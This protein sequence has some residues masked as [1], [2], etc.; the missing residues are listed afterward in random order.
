MEFRVWSSLTWSLL[1]LVQ[2]V[3]GYEIEQAELRAPPARPELHLVTFLNKPDR[4]FVYLQVSAEAHD[5]QPQYLGMG[6]A[7]VWPH[8]L[9]KVKL[10][11]HYVDLK[12]ADNDIVIFADAFDVLVFGD[13]TE[14]ISKFE[15][16]EASK[17]RSIFFNAEI[18]CYPPTAVCEEPY[19]KAPHR[20]RY[21]NS[22][23]FVARGWALRKLLPEGEPEPQKKGDQEWY[24]KQFHARPDLVALDYECQLVCPI[25]GFL[26]EHGAEMW[27]DNRIHIPDTNSMPPLVHFVSWAHWTAWTGMEAST[28]LQEVFHKLYQKESEYVLE[29]WWIG[30]YIGVTHDIQVYRGSG[31]WRTMVCWLCFACNVLGSSQGECRYFEGFFGERCW[32]FSLCLFASLG[33]LCLMVQRKWTTRREKDRST[34]PDDLGRIGSS[35]SLTGVARRFLRSA[36]RFPASSKSP[37]QQV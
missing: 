29:G 21:L 10:L 36:G 12:V 35:S 16:L 32:L 15:E 33:S 23:L 6:Q 1:L 20:W 2:V 26:P 7:A 34:H 5:L 9:V 4:K 25:W 37:D 17:N 14:I 13:K 11:R 3:H 24:Q 28:T 30:A 18:V 27:E 22:G 31:F 8:L 19:P